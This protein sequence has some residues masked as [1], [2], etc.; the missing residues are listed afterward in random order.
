M[1]LQNGGMF[2]KSDLMS[3]PEAEI[4]DFASEKPQYEAFGL[5]MDSD[6]NYA[7]IDNFEDEGVPEKEKERRNPTIKKPS[8]LP[9]SGS[10]YQARI[11]SWSIQ[12]VAYEINER[13]T[14]TGAPYS[15]VVF[16]STERGLAVPGI[17][18]LDLYVIVGEEDDFMQ[19]LA[20][21]RP[22]YADMQSS[23]L[24]KEDAAATVNRVRAE[25]GNE[26]RKLRK[27]GI[28]DPVLTSWIKTN[29]SIYTEGEFKKLLD[30]VREG[31]SASFMIPVSGKLF[32]VDAEKVSNC[33]L[34]YRVIEDGLGIS[35]LL[36][37]T[38]KVLEQN[39]TAERNRDYIRS[40]ARRLQKVKF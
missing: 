15:L 6:G 21:F 12:N 20:G 17:S 36:D 2:R 8:P 37:G 35:G 38:R 39:G 10:G 7:D 29:E 23:S 3:T 5:G 9:Y 22:E 33:L 4:N 1:L 31:Q 18:D 30:A 11:D 27:A 26:R 13:L 34:R 24:S 32:E 16:G 25:L 40:K 14:Q 28:N 19:H